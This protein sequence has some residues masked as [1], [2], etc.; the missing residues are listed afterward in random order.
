MGFN[1]GFKGLNIGQKAGSPDWGVSWLSSVSS[2]TFQVS[3]SSYVTRASCQYFF[4]PVI[5]SFEAFTAVWFSISFFWGMTLRHEIIGSQRFEGT[6]CLHPSVIRGLLRF[7]RHHVSSEPRTEH[8]NP[9][10]EDPDSTS[11]S[12]DT[13]SVVRW[14]MLCN[15]FWFCLLFYTD[16]SDCDRALPSFHGWIATDWLSN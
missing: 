8:H 16:F 15:K 4:S 11:T 13:D 12:W 1:S 5:V 2:R 10:E 6:R 7:R 3:V 9:E 14:T